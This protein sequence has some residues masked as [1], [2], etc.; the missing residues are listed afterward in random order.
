MEEEETIHHFQTKLCD[1]LTK[2]GLII[3]STFKSKRFSLSCKA[4]L[5][6]QQRGTSSTD[7]FSRFR[8]E[9]LEQLCLDKKRHVL[10]AINEF[11]NKVMQLS[12]YFNNNR[13]DAERNFASLPKFNIRALQVSKQLRKDLT[14]IKDDWKKELRTTL[15]DLVETSWP[16]WSDVQRISRSIG[17][18]RIKQ[19]NNMQSIAPDIGRDIYNAFAAESSKELKCAAEKLLS[20]MV[21]KFEENTQELKQ[22]LLNH[23]ASA[24]FQT[25]IPKLE[26]NQM[27]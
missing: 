17:L 16:K 6:L 4:E 22:P 2:N 21:N 13:Q 9:L 11:R 8:S 18:E 20:L 15:V 12:D 23:Q 5:Q 27:H 7:H 19:S 10:G 26:A 3:N 1:V 25:A 24:F 14:K